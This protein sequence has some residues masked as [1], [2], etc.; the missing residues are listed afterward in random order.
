MILASVFGFVFGILLGSFSHFPIWMYIVIFLVG[1]IFFLYRYF[2]EEK[3]A[4]YTTLASVFILASLVGVL[5]VN[6]SDL[7]KSSSLDNF[8]GK[9]ILAEGIVVAE[10]DVRE[11]NTKLTISLNQIISNSQ[12]TEVKENILVTVPVYPE[13]RYGDKLEMEIFLEEPKNFEN[14]SGRMFDYVGYLRV[15]GIWYISRY[16]KVELLASDQGSFIK[17]KLFTIKG[18]FTKSINNALPEPESSLLS[19]LLLGGKQSL[20]KD[21]IL[22]FQ[23]TGT[24]HIVVLSG[25]NIAI[26]ANSIISFFGFLPKTLSFSFGVVGIILFTILSGGGA[27]AWRAAIMVLTAI[28]AKRLN[29]DFVA[30]RALGFAVVVMLAPNPLLLVFDPSFELSILATIGLIFVTPFVT[31]HL[32]FITEKFNLRE[33]VSSTI[34]TQTT[35]LPLLI[36]STGLIS[37]VS[38]PVNVLI[39]GTIPTTMFFGFLTGVF[40]FVSYYLSLI[41]ALFTY[42]LLWYQLEVV[43]LGSSLPFSAVSLPTFSPI[44]L[45]VVY[46]AIFLSLGFLKKKI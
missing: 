43:H 34:A 38:L 15:R 25:Y 14:E 26:V 24:S 40:G 20:G 17:S 9:K 4:L 22:E 46:L 21:L 37:V 33:I 19:G 41:P 11:S 5:R 45:V 7:Y 12:T 35:V 8:A 31:P 32:S 30:S 39:L 28:F 27:S 6:F 23:K 36:Y 16:G 13:Y 42:A 1:T 29:R 44:I 18:A 3:Q 2:V 10:P